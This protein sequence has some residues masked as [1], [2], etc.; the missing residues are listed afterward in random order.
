ML[1]LKSLLLFNSVLGRSEKLR[2][3]LVRHGRFIWYTDGSILLMASLAMGF[4]VNRPVQDSV[5]A[6]NNTVPSYKS[7]SVTS[8]LVQMQVLPE[9]LEFCLFVRLLLGLLTQNEITSILVQECFIASRNSA[10]RLGSCG[11]HLKCAGKLANRG[12]CMPFF[13]PEQ[14]CGISKATVNHLIDKWSRQQQRQRCCS[15]TGQALGKK[16]PTDSSAHGW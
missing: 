4:T 2:R 6:W 8:W 13:G 14:C 1:S 9:K 15:Y 5:P 12:A 10:S 16:L 11:W 7:K 3:C